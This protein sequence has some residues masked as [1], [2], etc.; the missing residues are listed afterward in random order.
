MSLR[1]DFVMKETRLAIYKRDGYTCQY[2]KKR[3]GEIK[4][5]T[6]D[7]IEPRTNGGQHSSDNLVTS[8]RS[9]NSRKRDQTL[10]AF[11][12][13]KSAKKIK[14]QAKKSLPVVDQ[15]SGMFDSYLDNL[16]YE[17]QIA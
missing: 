1:S 16:A 11:V 17:L 12:G 13:S 2:C 15:P 9:C 14:R 10:V 3:I 6:L 8:C 5:I 7:H 4:D